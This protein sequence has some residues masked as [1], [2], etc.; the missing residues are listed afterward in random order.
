[1][2]GLEDHVLVVIEKAAPSPTRLPARSGPERGTGPS[3]RATRYPRPMRV[4]VLS[5]IHANL[6]ALD[7]VLEPNRSG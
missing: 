5:D 6:R 3:S 1:M 4:A 7:A 2:I